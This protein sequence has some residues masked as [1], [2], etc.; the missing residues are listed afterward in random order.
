MM[1]VLQYVAKRAGFDLPL[2]AGDK[3]ILDSGGRN[4]T[5]TPVFSEDITKTSNDPLHTTM[6]GISILQIYFTKS[7]IYFKDT[8]TIFATFKTDQ[9]SW[10]VRL[11]GRG[12]ELRDNL[13]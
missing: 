11:Q 7:I 9:A 12:L 6:S 10:I 4:W 1:M 13:P 3:I 5:A 8:F 2:A